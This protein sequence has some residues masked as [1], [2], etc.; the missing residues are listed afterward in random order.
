MAPDQDRRA[1]AAAPSP[2]DGGYYLC[3][4]ART[5]QEFAVV[6]AAS[7]E[8]VE[9]TTESEARA[10]VD[11]RY[12]GA[13]FVLTTGRSVFEGEDL[14]QFVV[15]MVLQQ[16]AVGQGWRSV[17]C[18]GGA[19]HGTRCVPFSPSVWPDAIDSIGVDPSRVSPASAAP[20]DPPAR[21]PGEDVLPPVD[22]P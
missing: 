13:R 15:M 11:R 2:P 22:D 1:E 5:S 7:G 10:L 14:G 9:L 16:A 4:L 18:V 19:A 6:D 20:V 21:S 8:I 3:D 17:A 12:P